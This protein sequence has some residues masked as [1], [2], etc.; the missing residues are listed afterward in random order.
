[1]N[2]YIFKKKKAKMYILRSVIVC[3]LLHPPDGL[4]L[5]P[6]EKSFKMN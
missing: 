1:M 4:D 2:T 6:T 5:Y 3:Y